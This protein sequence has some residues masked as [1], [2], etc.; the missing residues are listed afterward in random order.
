MI[1]ELEKQPIKFERAKRC[2]GY[3]SECIDVFDHFKCWMG[4]ITVIEGSLII[5][6]PADGYCPYVNG[7]KNI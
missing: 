1:T 2:S 5:C 3:D 7:M 4:E 6:E